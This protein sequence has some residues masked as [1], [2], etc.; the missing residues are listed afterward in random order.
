MLEINS[1]IKG[2]DKKLDKKETNMYTESQR[3]KANKL[4]KKN[5]KISWKI[6][7]L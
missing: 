6:K 4:Y 1:P 5:D 7:L 2:A 3:E